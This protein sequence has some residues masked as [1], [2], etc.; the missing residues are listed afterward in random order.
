MARKKT[1]KK[2][3]AEPTSPGSRLS[4]AEFPL[5]PLDQALKVASALQDDF[6]GRSGP[7]HDVAF[8]LGVSPTSSSWRV[9]TGAAIAYGLTEGGYNA[10]R[11]HLT[12]L[13]RRIVAPEEEGADLVAKV[14]A[15]LR[16]KIIRQ[17]FEKYDRAKFPQDVIAQNV[18]ASLGVPRDRVADGV[19]LL[20]QVGKSVGIVRETK[21]GPFVAI[22]A[23]GD[24]QREFSIANGNESGRQPLLEDEPVDQVPQGNPVLKEVPRTNNRVFISHGK[25]RAVV[26]QIKDLLAFG[27]FEPIV[28]VEQE[29]TA[30]PVPEKVFQDM[31]SCGAG[32]I[33]VTS[34][35]SFMNQAGESKVF[36]NQNVLIEI[37]AAS[38]LYGKRVVL[39]VERGIELPSNLQGLYRCD[40]EGGK[41]DYESTMKLLK[42]FNQ[43]REI[44]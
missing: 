19:T 3:S 33:H 2:A 36:I 6:G 22:Q 39:L 30:I 31:R 43:F 26:L 12:P 7:P 13:G 21:T 23:A 4:Q 15:A 25:D 32:V 28:S 16:P 18:L 35:G 37:G 5:M 11:I 40:Y 27:N 34:E 8:S 24:L 9:L 1:F 17:F 41:L 20:R 42:T 38:A 44:A 14:E 10:D 29:R